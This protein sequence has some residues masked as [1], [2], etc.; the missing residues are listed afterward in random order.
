MTVRLLTLLLPEYHTNCNMTA[1]PNYMTIS[2]YIE[3][4]SS[5]SLSEMSGIKLMN[6]VDT[7]YLMPARL[8]LDLLMKLDGD[9][10]VQ[11]VNGKRL[12][13]YKTMYYDTGEIEMY[14][15]HHD[16]RINRIKVRTRTYLDSGISFL[17]IKKKDNKGRTKKTRIAIPNNNFNNFSE[18]LEAVEFLERKSGYLMSDIKPHVSSTFSRI[19]LVNNNKTERIT[20]D[21][22][23]KFTNH[24]TNIT[25]GVPELVIIELKQ[26]G[27]IH[28]TLRDVLAE[29]RV[30]P[31]GVSKYCLGTALTNKEAKINRFKQK[32]RYIEKLTLI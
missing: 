5:I 17:E 11:E 12:A 21:T 3:G 18:N 28:S 1:Q 4:M 9:F 20:I 29:F 7:K 31:G 15:M 19:T 10:R 8:L 2:D 6:R 14:V 22:D 23:L 30:F 16:R 27:R 24:R 13:S 26:D 25:A 32:L